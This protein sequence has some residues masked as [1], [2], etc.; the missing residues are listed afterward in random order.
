MSPSESGRWLVDSSFLIGLPTWA[1]AFCRFRPLYGMNVKNLL[2]VAVTGGFCKIPERYKMFRRRSTA[3]G[4]A[5]SLLK[6]NF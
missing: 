5:Y 6:A 2:V 3:F 4:S 1:M